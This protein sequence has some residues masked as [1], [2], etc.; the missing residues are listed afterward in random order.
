[1]PYATK[2]AMIDRFAEREVI[3]LTDRD[4]GKALERALKAKHALGHPLDAV[5]GL[6]CGLSDLSNALR[7]GYARALPAPARERGGVLCG[8]DNDVDAFSH[9]PA[10]PTWRR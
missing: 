9:W 10:V 5:P 8:L 7:A 3:A 2:Q 6:L 4:D 1:M